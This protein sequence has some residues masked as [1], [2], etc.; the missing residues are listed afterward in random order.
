MFQKYLR[1]ITLI[2]LKY[3]NKYYKQSQTLKKIMK[4]II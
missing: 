1:D 4:I 2:I 3:F